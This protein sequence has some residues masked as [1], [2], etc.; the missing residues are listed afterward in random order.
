MS[1][2]IAT[3]ESFEIKRDPD[4][5]GGRDVRLH[6][7]VGRHLPAAHR[8]RLEPEPLRALPQRRSLAQ[9]RQIIDFHYDHHD[10]RKS[11]Y[12]L[13]SDVFY[14]PESD[15][16]EGTPQLLQNVDLNVDGLSKIFDNSKGKDPLHIAF[17]EAVELLNSVTTSIKD[18]FTFDTTTTS[19]TTVS[20]E[21]AGIS[22][23]R[24]S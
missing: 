3:N 1:D 23:W 20:G 16:E 6:A 13:F 10:G 5:G 14:G 24:K 7:P 11:E 18:A 9:G 2:P 22:A 12:V 8:E 21:Y 4:D 17:S 15:F 19:E